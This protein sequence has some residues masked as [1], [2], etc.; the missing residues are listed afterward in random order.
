M[1]RL[2]RAASLGSTASNAIALNATD[3]ARCLVSAMSGHD[4]I[5][6]V[7]GCVRR[8][9][10][11]LLSMR[12]SSV[13]AASRSSRSRSSECHDQERSV[14]WRGRSALMPILRPVESM[15]GNRGRAP[16]PYFSGHFRAS[17]AQRFGGRCAGFRRPACPSCAG[18]SRIP[19]NACDRSSR[20]NRACRMPGAGSRPASVASSGSAG[21]GTAFALSR[22]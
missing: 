22:W 10:P 8:C 6:H 1:S 16:K 9:R 14:L 17:L 12:A 7:R 20:S 18:P 3:S 5:G 15:Y 11:A 2:R 13:P 4:K 21:C 19:G